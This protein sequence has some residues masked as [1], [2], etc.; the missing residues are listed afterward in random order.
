MKQPQYYI[1][2]S[3]TTI[4]QKTLSNSAGSIVVYSPLNDVRAIPLSLQN[5]WY[6]KHQEQLLKDK[7]NI[8]VNKLIDE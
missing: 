3:G 7:I 4:T 1:I 2:D 5:D 6:K 8:N